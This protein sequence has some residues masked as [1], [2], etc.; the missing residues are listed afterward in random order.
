MI[1]N[2][3][4]KRRKKPQK[5]KRIDIR[6][7]EKPRRLAQ[8]EKW[9]EAGL[10]YPE[11]A[12]LIGITDRTFINWRSKSEQIRNASKVGTKTMVQELRMK[13]FEKA[14]GHA[15]IE[16]KPFVLTTTR[17]LAGKGKITESRVE[18]VDVEVYY[19]P[20]TNALKFAL[21]NITQTD[22]ESDEDGVVWRLADRA[23][24][25][26]KQEPVEIILRREKTGLDGCLSC[27]A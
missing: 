11:I 12:G 25:Q 9:R 20:D 6:Q 23:G 22:T 7:W 19:P 13:L 17:E 5:P 24:L 16:R 3:N 21:A 14:M 26:E 18:M 8:L 1:A 2:H 27:L 10:T 15:R 4:A